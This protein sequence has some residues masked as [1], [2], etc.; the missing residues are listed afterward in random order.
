MKK[1]IKYKKWLNKPNNLL[2]INDLKQSNKLYKTK[3]SINQWEKTEININHND[4]L[5][6]KKKL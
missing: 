6:N 3:T 4:N 1:S 2:D 5:A